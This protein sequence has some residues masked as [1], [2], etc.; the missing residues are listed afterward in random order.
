MCT[1]QTKV[2]MTNL[3]I[4]KLNEMYHDGEKDGGLLEGFD[5]P[6]GDETENLHQREH[7]NSVQLNLNKEQ[8]NEL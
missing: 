1:L 2:S 8:C 5:Q 7:V 6:Q 4:V 3:L